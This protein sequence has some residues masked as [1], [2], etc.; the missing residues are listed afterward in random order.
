[1]SDRVCSACGSPKV[2]DGFLEDRGEGSQGYVRWI[3]GPL[4]RG[5]FGGAKRVGKSRYAVQ[6]LRCGEC[7]HLDL[8]VGEMT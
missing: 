3:Q 4:Q 1:M 7:D 6:G 2:E 8:W 5:F